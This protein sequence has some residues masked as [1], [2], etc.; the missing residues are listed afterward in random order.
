M[1]PFM[2]LRGARVIDPAHGLDAVR[3]LAI[4]EGRVALPGD[5][6]ADAEI[7]RMDGCVITPGLVDL[8]VHL[9]EPGQAHKE[10][11]ET[12]TRAAAAGGFTTILAMP[13]TA[14]AIDTPEQVRDILSQYARRAAVRVLQ[15][16]ALSHGRHGE[17]ITDAAA[18][19]GAGAAALTDDGSCI[20]NPALM[21]DAMRRAAA[22]GLPVIDHCED[23][24]LARG[25]AMRAGPVADRLGLPGMPAAAEELMVARN[26][27][28]AAELGAP[29]HLQHLSSA[30]S[31]ALLRWAKGQGIPV[32]GEV[33]PHHLCLTAEAC[34][35]H[36]TLAKMN[37]P[38][39][40]E[41]DR[42]ALIAALADGTIDAVA[43]DHAP[44]AAE[45]KARPFAAAP[46]GIIGLE[47]ALALCLTELV[48]T[49]RMPLAVLVE[50]LT[51]APRRI[52]GLPSGSLVPGAPADLAV[53][54]PN[55][56]WTVTAA[57]LFSKSHN[58]PFLGR[59]CR[60]RVLCTMIDGRRVYE[61]H[62]DGSIAWLPQPAVAQSH[63]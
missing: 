43:T 31:A 35:E 54:D 8:H 10:T 38:L 29:V 30:R 60:G 56:E 40:T 23:V 55:R 3:D 59:R 4:A 48:H 27:L 57:D 32:T 19:K 50:R 28:L 53:F 1:P 61:R 63:P 51:A 12:G 39:G 14:P 34:A 6:P 49:G 24:P 62:P 18:L 7:V 22:A 17:T 42:Q 21:R 20:Q 41:A 47:T 9:R 5:L 16:A 46:F 26:I 33:T 13:N 45:E 11:I 15:S 2:I 58:T 36:G 52:L 37:P 44:H 25:G